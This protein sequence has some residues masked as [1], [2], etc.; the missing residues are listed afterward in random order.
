MGD[1]IHIRGAR[2]HNL[3]NINVDIPHR[4][5]VVVTGL[6]GSGKSSLVFDTLHAE[7]QRQF[8]EAHGTIADAIRKPQV[9]RIEG[10]SPSIAIGQHRANRNPRSTVGT[11]TD[12]YSYLRVLYARIGHQPCPQC[13]VDIPPPY[14]EQD[15]TEVE[16]EEPIA[17]EMAESDVE[18][19]TF[20]TCPSCRAKIGQL[21]I[22]HFSFNSPTGACSQCTGL[23]TVREPN[24]ERLIDPKRS[25]LDGG[26]LIWRRRDAETL[27]GV[28]GIAAHKYGFPFDLR[29]PVGELC[30][31]ARD[32]L[33]Y[34]TAS[35][36]FRRHFPGK[37]PLMT[38]AEGRYEGIVTGLL[39]RYEEHI[40]DPEYREQVEQ[41]LEIHICPMCNGDRLRPE[42]RRVTIVG[43]AISEVSRMPL[44]EVGVWLDNLFRELPEQEAQVAGSILDDLRERVRKLVEVG[45]GYLTLD[46]PS[47]S[48]SPGEAQRLRLAALLG[49]GLTGVLY[50]LDEPT[51][52][53]HPRDTQALIITL[54]RLRDLGNTVVVVEHDLDIV[55][56][57]DYVIE[58]GAGAGQGGGWVI[59]AGSPGELAGVQESAT[60]AWLMAPPTA[61]R[62][63]RRRLDSAPRLTIRG[64]RE[65][66]LK[67][68]TVSIPLGG[69]V[70]VTGVS[71]SGK[72][73]L[74]LDILARVAARR[75][76]HTGDV[77]GKHD[78]IEGWGGI[79]KVV[80]LDQTPLS[81]SP[82]SNAATYTGIFK[83]I[84]EAFAST[85]GARK[86]GF[87]PR[88]FSFNV[89]G[90]RCERCQGGG[91]LQ[92][93]MYF[94]PD[95]TVRCPSC[96][97]SR[98]KKEILSVAYRGYSIYD[99]IEMTV[100]ESYRL[101]VDVPLAAK[102]LRVMEDVGLGYLKVGQ[103]ATTLSGGEA[104]RVKLA[105]E[106]G[107]GRAT[108]TLYIRDEPT[109]GLHAADVDRLLALLQRLVDA[110]NTVV[111]IEHNLDM[112]KS[113]DWLVDLG[114]EGG[115]AGGSLVAQGTPEMVARE[116]T[117]Y[118]GQFLKTMPQG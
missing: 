78:A 98:F 50:V 95:A 44:V 108:Q 17:D 96:H 102:M 63:R 22:G 40:E 51:V 32:G 54:R 43:R 6:S 104:Q 9:E 48:L 91:E 24:L 26:V 10:L 71:G 46:Q 69:L 3:K 62:V 2:L 114:P 52:G 5:L 14:D 66:N 81:R 31:E 19:P 107:Q 79:S 70:A 4:K 49:S 86:R 25:L 110:G 65:H 94:L 60:G 35:W 12:I 59:F 20:H 67:N 99:A 77:P 115:E 18:S 92:V 93:H 30:E 28:V 101:F 37:Q 64:A 76:N 33:L 1:T 55:R 42:S 21:S 73:T 36:R 109:T 13:G 88:H 29:T 116:P 53:L 15:A 57:A 23:G 97:G 112:I 82:R 113:A 83:P 100:S 90:G 11:A 118:T 45:V 27:G 56:S 89:S 103:P 105:T 117:S 87:T 84:R 41:L 7:G 34:G 16:G 72:S 39:R 61:T 8:Q 106:L 58:I 68:I 111:V 74:L 80:V 75:F 47:P 38:M 85:E